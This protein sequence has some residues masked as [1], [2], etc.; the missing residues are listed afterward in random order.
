[1]KLRFLLFLSIIAMILASCSELDEQNWNTSENNSEI[2][3][4]IYQTRN[5]NL[6]CVK[7]HEI[8]Y[9]NLMTSRTS[10]NEDKNGNSGELLGFSYKIGNTILGDPQNVGFQVIEVNKVI[11]YEPSLLSRNRIGKSSINSFSYTSYDDFLQK[12]QLTKKSSSGFSINVFNLFKIGRKKKTHRYS[13][14]ILVTLHILC[15]VRQMLL[16]TIQSLS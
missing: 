14:H 13:L 12:S 7:T 10:G 4:T 15:T 6:P 8:V 1:M 3:D 9:V 11:D 16:I 2:H 5:P